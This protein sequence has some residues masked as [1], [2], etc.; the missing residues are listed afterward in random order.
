MEK[1]VNANGKS[2][3]Q[4]EKISYNQIICVFSTMSFPHENKVGEKKTR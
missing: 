1:S 3:K 4:M 2:V